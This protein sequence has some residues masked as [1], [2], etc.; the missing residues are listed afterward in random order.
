MFIDNYYVAVIDVLVFDVVVGFV[1][2]SFLYS[3]CVSMHVRTS[4]LVFL[5]FLLVCCVCF[6]DVLCR[7][8]CFFL[9]KSVSST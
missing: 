1:C 7:Y 3:L 6:V 4:D 9:T 8:T 2:R 5:F